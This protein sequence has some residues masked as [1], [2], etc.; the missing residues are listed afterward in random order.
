MEIERLK[1]AVQRSPGDMNLWCSLVE[2][3]L[4]TGDTTS[5]EQNLNY[6]LKME[7]T[8][9]LYMHKA[10]ICVNRQDLYAAARHAASAV[11]MGLKPAEDSTVYYIDS[12]SGGYVYLC[13][14]R[15]AKEDKKNVS[16]WVGL[17]QIA[18]MHGD[19][20]AALPYYEAAYHLGDSIAGVMIAQ[21]KV[22]RQQP[23]DE[24]E[25]IAEIPYTYQSEMLEVKCR[26]NGLAIRA[27]I[28]TTATQSSI[29]DVE[30]KFMLKNEYI[31]KDDI[32]DNTSV[33]VK[34]ME[35]TDTILLE[36]VL[37]QYIANQDYAVVL[38]LRDLERL[39][40]VRINERKRVIEITR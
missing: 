36:N 26:L 40:H 28:D 21:L 15:M 38:C 7:E 16:L 39:G 20:A 2:A 23:D 27:T 11:R 1:A 10:R 33:M 6:S 22:S 17:G 25:V 14:Q 24:R 18:C 30:T 35:L 13:M 34:R 19:T 12:L 3:Q 9:C 4:A 31:S 29:S 5:A 37:L 32:R 8:A